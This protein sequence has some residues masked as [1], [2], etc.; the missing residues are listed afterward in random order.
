MRGSLLAILKTVSPV[1]AVVLSGGLAVQYQFV[2]LGIKAEASSQLK[3]WYTDT[4]KHGP[5][6]PGLSPSLPR[7]T[8]QN[9]RRA[10]PPAVTASIESRLWYG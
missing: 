9:L 10:Q 6:L 2:P 8:A 7:R 5:L 1:I 4:F 3:R